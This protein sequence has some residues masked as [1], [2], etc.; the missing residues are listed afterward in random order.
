MGAA[1]MGWHRVLIVFRGMVRGLT[2]TMTASPSCLASGMISPRTRSSPMI[3]SSD[4]ARVRT[5][6]FTSLT[7]C[8]VSPPT[9]SATCS[10]VGSQF[11]LARNSSVARWI[12][13]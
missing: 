2:C 6:A 3:A 4:A 10:S 9:L 8:G 13:E 12:L 1:G 11:E 5:C 7:F